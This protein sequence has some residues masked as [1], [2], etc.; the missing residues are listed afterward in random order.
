M[1]LFKYKA[2][3][4]DGEQYDGTT[5]AADRFELYTHIQKEGGTIVSYKEEGKE[6]GENIINSVWHLFFGRIKESDKIVLTRNLGAML[7]AGLSLSRALAVMNRQ[8]KNKKLKDV[9]ESISHSIEKGGAFNEALLE[10]P[11]VFSPIMAAMV[12]AGEESGRL[13]ESLAT[14][15]EQLDRSYT[16]K[17]KIRGAL[18]YPAIVIF[19]L[20][21][22][23]ILMLIFIVP[24]LTKTFNEIHVE[25]PA[26]TK[27]IIGL[28]D[29]LTHHTVSALIIAIATFV[30]ASYALRTRQG[31]RGFEWVILRIPVIGELVKET[32][33]AR[34][35]RTLSSLLSSGVEI[36]R[37]IDITKEVLQN[38]Y[39]QDVLATAGARI[40]KG[41]PLAEVFN[42]NESLYPPLVAELIAVGEETG[43]LPDMLLEV[44]TFYEREVEMKTKDMSTIIEPFL[45]LIVGTA[46]GFFA[47]SMITPIYSIT[48]NI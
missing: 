3:N 18:M 45:M 15:A 36:V 28:S 33:S 31:R 30:G 14:I 9:L 39:Y 19:A 12:K 7:S 35:A 38:S 26:T 48:Q 11:K 34:T 20:I 29:F 47:V 23:G 43:K 21:V 40:Q 44:A 10:F 1:T 22:V 4:K 16:L 37:A 25:L 27:F 5:T 42:A 46:V 2:I 41:A 8:S 32:N 13:A 24:T 17:K 6:S